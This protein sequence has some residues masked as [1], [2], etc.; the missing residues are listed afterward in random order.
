MI[1][2]LQIKNMLMKWMILNK[3]LVLEMVNIMQKETFI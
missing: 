2:I 3:L 1:I